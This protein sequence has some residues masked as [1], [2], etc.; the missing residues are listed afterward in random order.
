[1]VSQGD[2][3]QSPAAQRD[4]LLLRQTIEDAGSMQLTTFESQA[5]LETAITRRRVDFGLVWDGVAL[6]FF[7]D[8]N[9][10][11]ENFAFEQAARAIATEFN[12]RRQNV[13]RSLPI[14]VISVGEIQSI[15]WYN[16]V[17]PGI[18]AFSV[19]S[20]GLFAVSGHLTQMKQRNILDR[21]I[22]TPMP[23]MALL[24]AIVVVR[25]GVVFISTLITLG[26][27]IV[28]FGLQFEIDW[29]RYVIFVICA[30]LG[31]MG[32][33][34]IIA[35]LVRRPSSASSLANVL[36]M[37]MM[38]FAGIYFPI[39]FMPAFLRALSK[40]LPLTHMANAMRYVTGVIEM[41]EGEFWAITFALLGTA[42]VLFPVLARYV[43]RPTRN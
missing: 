36:A 34:T 27:G 42:V 21:L 3:S 8:A 4:A 38:F 28:V 11:Q 14:D 30:T 19:L 10:I 5:E 9:R 23:P 32:M 41:S 35:L 7:Y 20:A 2:A 29:F 15:G 22:V 12:L 1:I 31:T 13:T 37:V 40:V 25:L 43:V 6:R 18:L 17:L 16:L 24:S 33:G 39:E 26:V